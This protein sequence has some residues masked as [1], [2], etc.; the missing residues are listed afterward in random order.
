MKLLKN[1]MK[2]K[3]ITNKIVCLALLFMSFATMEAQVYKNKMDSIVAAQQVKRANKAFDNLSYVKAVEKYEKLNE[4][5]HLSDSVKGLLGTAY[6]KLNETVKS[7]E[8]LSTIA[9]DKMN[10][11][12]LLTYYRALGYN[13]KYGEADRVMAVYQNKNPE[14]VF[15]KELVNSMPAIEKLL[16][17]KNY[18]VEDINCNSRESDFAPVVYGDRLYFASSRELD[19][20]IKREYSWNDSPYINVLSAKIKKD[21]VLSNPKIFSP[22]MRSMYHDGPVCF[23][24]DGNEI[25]I[26]RN[27][28]HSFFKSIFNGKKDYNTLVLLKSEKQE[29]GS[30]SKPEKL[31][32][33]SDA[34]SCGQ[35]CL[36]QSGDTL[37]FTSNMPGGFGGTDIYFVVRKGSEWSEPVNLGEDINTKGDEMFPFAGESGRIYFASNGHVGLGGLDIYAA[38]RQGAGFELKNMGAPVNSKKDDFALFLDANGKHGYFSSNREG[39]KGD[40]DIYQFQVLKDLSFIKNIKGI[41]V[42]KTTNQVI[43]N[44]LI[45]LKAEDGDYVKDFTTDSLGELHCELDDVT[46]LVAEANI[47]GY[48]PYKDMLDL[49]D[50]K[51][52]FKI[53]LTP[54]PVWGIFG[55]VFLM[56]DRT[57]IPEVN[58]KVESQDADPFTEVS[59]DTGD[60]KIKLKPDTDYSLVFNKKGFFTKR[61]PY[62]TYNRKP[63][64]VNVNEFVELEMQKAEVGQSIEIEILYDLGKWNIRE[65][66]AVELDDMIRFLKDNPTVKIELGSHTDSRGS[67]KYNMTLSQKR[68]DSA[69]QYMVNHGIDRSRVVAKGYG[70]TRLKNKCADGVPCSEAEHQVN[71]RSEVTIL[72]M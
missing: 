26:T 60:F 33:N 55:A 22:S 53:E 50:D 42:D 43:T 61:V 69:V 4:K 9:L 54:K 7:E 63:G 29:D 72:E 58:V 34:Y 68:A 56:P 41:V 66:A 12:Q 19:Y 3:H 38:E 57:P 5:D 59:D 45:S 64:Y 44:S 10:N 46:K 13:G 28:Y 20:V 1:N 18:N 27:E 21:S 70:E 52:E 62:S 14:D 31:A 65:D 49:S 6:L 25:F 36:T 35:A 47:D 39:G 2:N 40:D 51:G 32:F 11:D 24:K 15:A 17:D 30:W 16:K 8:I 23:S 71:R 67:A 37:Y 48:Y